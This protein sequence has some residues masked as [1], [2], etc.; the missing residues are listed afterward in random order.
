VLGK[1]YDPVLAEAVDIVPGKEDNK[2]VEVLRKG[3]R[4]GT[5]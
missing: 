1:A 4:F 3:Y 5:K 2:V